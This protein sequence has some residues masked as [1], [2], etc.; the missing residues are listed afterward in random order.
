MNLN[1]ATLVFIVVFWMV[2]LTWWWISGLKRG[3]KIITLTG[4]SGAGKTVI[5]RELLKNH[6]EWKMVL[7]LTSRGPRNSDLP[8][9][10]KCDVVQEEF[11]WRDRRGEFIWT[12]SAHGNIYGTLLADI[13]KALNSEY[14]LL[15]QILSE[16]VKQLRSYAPNKVLSIFI[17]PPDGSELKQRLEKRGE[18]PEQIER[19]IA[20][21]KKWEEEA[22]SSGIPYEFVRNDGTV[23]EAVEKVEKVIKQRT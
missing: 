16:S 5:T 10:Y 22:R 14:P 11:F 3:V 15:M 2:V 18:S 20:D 13:Q 12:V 7:S 8:G 4:P 1:L 21:C 17:L 9:E 19:R 23:E 6:P